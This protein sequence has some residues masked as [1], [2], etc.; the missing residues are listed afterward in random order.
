MSNSKTV[1]WVRTVIRKEPYPSFL[2]KKE[3]DNI[4]ITNLTIIE[5]GEIMLGVA[6]IS[7]RIEEGKLISN[8]F[9]SEL[10]IEDFGFKE[11]D[12]LLKKNGFELVLNTN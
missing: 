7:L 10:L 2:Y 5:I 12:Y 8:I 4:L 6:D 3:F 11:F 1:I 9:T